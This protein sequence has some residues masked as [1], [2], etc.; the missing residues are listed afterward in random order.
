MTRN[1]V[2]Q[3]V[4]NP[5]KIEDFYSLFTNALQKQ[6][7]IWI[8]LHA[9]RS[10]GGRL[11]M[12]KWKDLLIEIEKIEEKYGTRLRNPASDT[13]I[14]KM[15]KNFQRKFGNI[16]L[17]ESYREFLKRIN[18]LDFNGL[19]IYGVD[20]VL[21]ESEVDEEVHGLIETN[22]LWY[23]N[24]TQKQYIFY[25]DS[26]TVWYC[27]DLKEG[28]YVELDKPSGTLIQSYDSFESMLSD[29]L[30]SVIGQIELLLRITGNY[31]HNKRIKVQ[32]EKVIS[33]VVQK[34]KHRDHE[35]LNTLLL[36]L[37]QLSAALNNPSSTGDL[38][39][40]SKINGALRAC[41]DT[42]LVESYE[43]PLVVEL[44][45]LESMLKTP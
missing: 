37:Q 36:N 32:V 18:G 20:E 38:P 26:D 29:A 39:K 9:E 40:Y 7:V 10:L 17:P 27:Y 5:I 4:E 24:E 42:N 34:K 11:D 44:D 3:T 16:V 22:E 1:P 41:F 31:M 45:L 6:R 43:E 25:A 13:E 14:E 28:V 21:L 30:E 33:L 8:L 15:E 12:P 19:V 2:F 23:E 35:F